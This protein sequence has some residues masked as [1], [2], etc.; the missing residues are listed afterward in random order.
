MA[1]PSL[2]PDGLLPTGI[3]RATVEEI[4]ERF[5]TGSDRRRDLGIRLDQLIALARHVRARRMLV[6]GSFVTSKL[7]PGDLDI[8]VWLDDY[9]V[10]LLEA[11]DASAQML[12][13]LI[14]SRS[15]DDL[16]AVYNDSGWCEWADFFAQVAETGERRKGLIEVE[17]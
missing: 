14:V 4:L 5:G 2:D 10:Q 17:L 12:E 7:E 15:S 3:H 6:D 8:V 13:R 11:Q 1:I 9:Y 16:F